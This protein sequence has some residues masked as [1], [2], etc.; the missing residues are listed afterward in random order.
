MN[1]SKKHQTEKRES[2]EFFSGKANF[3]HSRHT[4]KALILA[5]VIEIV[6]IVLLA[7]THFPSQPREKQFEVSMQTE[8]F[9]FNQ[10]PKP[11]R[12]K[13]PDIEQYLNTTT[14][15]SNEW[16]EDFSEEEMIN[17]ETTNNETEPESETGEE[18]GETNPNPANNL[19][20]SAKKIPVITP[21]PQTKL[22][23]EEKSYKGISRIK[24][25]VPG[26]RKRYLRNPLFTCP[27]N[28]HGWVRIDVV[29]DRSGKV[30]KAKFNP[31]QSTTNLGCLV[32]TALRYS[33]Q[34][35]FDSNPQ[36]PEK[37][38]GYILYLF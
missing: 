38:Y 2:G 6:L 19:E 7:N 8:D 34:T 5:A 37:V 17:E 24:Y 25:Y 29:V 20:N 33:Q 36:A 14:R 31:G 26:H 23:D 3:W 4:R 22:Y 32:E 16:Q 35:Q 28:M 1:E 13:L 30:L 27:D 9:D 21:K 10:L 12:E 18:P 11:E 15:A